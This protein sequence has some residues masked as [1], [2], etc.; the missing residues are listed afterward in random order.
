MGDETIAHEDTVTISKLSR[1]MS[2][3]RP[4]VG[5]PEEVA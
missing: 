5:L 3:L 1:S 4:M 2:I